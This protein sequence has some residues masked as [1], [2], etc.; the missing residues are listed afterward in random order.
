MTYRAS[1][2]TFCGSP[3]GNEEREEEE[4]G[5]WNAPGSLVLFVAELVED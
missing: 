3:F 4:E 5:S 1:V 2:G